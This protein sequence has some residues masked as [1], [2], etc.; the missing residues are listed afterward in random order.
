MPSRSIHTKQE[1]KTSG[2]K[3]GGIGIFQQPNRSKGAA[4]GI[5]INLS[6]I[7]FH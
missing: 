5:N 1:S 2:A 7:A 6:A 3:N 4:R